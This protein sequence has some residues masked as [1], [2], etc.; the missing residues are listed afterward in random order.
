M[1]EELFEEQSF[2][3]A[4]KL[5]DI[6]EEQD[7]EVKEV[8][9]PLSKTLM[10]IYGLNTPSTDVLNYISQKKTSINMMVVALFMFITCFVPLIILDS[11]YIPEV[12]GVLIMALM[13]FAGVVLIV[14]G[15]AGVKNEK[16]LLANLELSDEDH[17]YIEAE[18]E[19]YRKSQANNIIIA[20]GLFI[21][22]IFPVVIADTL[23][24]WYIADNFGIASMFIMI[25]SG[26]S[27]LVYQARNASL[28]KKLL[29]SDKKV[30]Y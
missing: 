22:S 17:E 9:P 5:S 11:L 10:E 25:A 24:P 20:V 6:L 30:H 7:E 12:F 3:D 14:K 27:L 1:K 29:R 8:L 13:I 15:N 26:V 16:S 4:Q 2:V 21:F 23:L 18:N 28:F 19:R